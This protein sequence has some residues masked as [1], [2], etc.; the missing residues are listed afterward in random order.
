ME[1]RPGKKPDL[2]LGPSLPHLVRDE[3]G[4]RPQELGLVGRGSRVG[5]GGRPSPGN[6]VGG[7][8][9]VDAAD[10]NRHVNEGRELQ[11][12]SDTSKG[13]DPPL[14]GQLLSDRVILSG[15]DV[16]ED[17]PPQLGDRPIREPGIVP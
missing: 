16:E 3:R 1:Q 5:T 12:C 7:V 10:A 11:W 14:C 15:G 17:R 6:G 2:W 4:E 8:G 9:E 13:A